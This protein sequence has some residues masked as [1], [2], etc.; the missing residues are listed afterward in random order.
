MCHVNTCLTARKK[1][2]PKPAGP[3]DYRIPAQFA[4]A[5]VEKRIRAAKTRRRIHFWED[6]CGMN[7]WSRVFSFQVRSLPRRWFALHYDTARRNSVA[8]VVR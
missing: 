8:L 3:L 2:P 1:N 6:Q 4:T 5:V 7:H